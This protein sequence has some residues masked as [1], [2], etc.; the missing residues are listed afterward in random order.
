[1]EKAAQ[2]PSLALASPPEMRYPSAGCLVPGVN[3]RVLSAGARQ[4]FSCRKVNFLVRY[5]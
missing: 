2:Q 3:R 1:M 5:L 4:G